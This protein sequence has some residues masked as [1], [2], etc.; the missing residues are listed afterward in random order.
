MKKFIAFF[1]AF[2]PVLLSGRPVPF[3]VPVERPP[4]W[5]RLPFL[6]LLP[7]LVAGILL[8]QWLHLPERTGAVT[9]GLAFSGIM[10]YAFLSVHRKYRW[11]PLC[12]G[13]LLLLTAALGSW[14]LAA[15]SLPQQQHWIG[16]RPPGTP[17]IV[18]LLEEPLEKGATWKATAEAEWALEGRELVPAR[19]RL[20]LYFAKGPRPPGAGDRLLVR[21][22]GQPVRGSRNPG[23]FDYPAW[24]ARQGITHQA[25]L[26]EN[27]YRVL[28]PDRLPGWSRLIGTA[29][30]FVLQALFNAISQPRERGLAEALLIGYRHHLDPELVQAYARTGVVHVIA[31][32]GL[33]IGLIYGILLGL[34]RPLARVRAARPLRFVLV[35][36]GL[37]GFSLLAG[38]GPSV[39]RSAVMFTFLAGGNLLGRKGETLNSLLASAFL[40]LLFNPYWLWDVGFQLSY[41]AVAS[42][43]LFYRPVYGLLYFSNRLVDGA[44]QLN[45]VTLSAQILTLPLTLGYFHQFPLLFL[46]TNFLAVPLSSLLLLGTILLCGLAPWPFLARSAGAVVE[47]GLSWLNRFI[48]A[49][50]RVPGA[51]WEGVQLSTAQV[52][53]LYLL[54]LSAALWIGTGRKKAA[55]GLGFSLLLLVTLRSVDFRRASVQQ[56]LIVYDGGRFLALDVLTSR[57]AEFMSDTAGRASVL[58]QRLFRP[59]RQLYRIH[60]VDTLRQPAF[61]VAG[62]R[63]L[64]LDASRPGP[65]LY[66]DRPH[67]LV[68][69]GAHR[70]QKERILR[71]IQPGRVVLSGSVSRRQQQQWEAA[72]KAAAIPCHAVNEKGAFVMNLR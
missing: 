24:C 38:A 61:S 45:A 62:V 58:E 16:H 50:D 17:L 49:A 36:A 60:S 8:Q 47:E 43:L 46:L 33:H 41:T 9:V 65:H 1:C 19:G 5:S 44:W 51:V 22:G 6:R 56:R 57:R 23:A 68:V 27:S 18:R 30:T 31:I 20:L 28:E 52:F 63:V 55:W 11:A 39:L 15:L 70:Q 12:G 7:P 53:L 42:L 34:T 72:C 25:Y 40:L 3:G 66:T 59:A 26:A 4:L 10:L 37:W 35:V 29:R 67:L 54:I 14:R 69:G 32:S 71:V 2:T 64:V 21:G 13:L 48:G